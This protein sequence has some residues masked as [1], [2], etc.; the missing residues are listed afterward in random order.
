MSFPA[1]AYSAVNKEFENK[2]KNAAEL[3]EQHRVYCHKKAPE[4]SELEN[5][6]STLGTKSVTEAIKAGKKARAVVE[7]YKKQSL[8]LQKQIKDILKYL[9]LDESYLT[10]QYSCKKCEDRG[11]IGVKMCDCYKKEL[12]RQSFAL[13]NL[14]AS[15]S[16]Q[17]F[18]NFNLKYYSDKKDPDYGNQSAR[19][20]IEKVFKFCKQ[21]AAQFSSESKNLMLKGQ[22][23]LG[24][25]HLS[26][27]IAKEVIE[28]G[29]WVAYET[30]QGIISKL[31]AEHF[32]K[33]E[34]V[35]TEYLYRCDLLIMDDLGAEFKT[36]FT[37]SAL[38][39]LIN[40]RIVSKKTTIISTNYT[41]DE[42]NDIYHER[43]NSRLK[44]DFLPLQFF[45]ED[46]RAKKQLKKVKG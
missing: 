23:G 34:D 12:I 9:E 41:D 29:H 45:G 5:L 19:E 16:E 4:I 26:S 8:D 35:K 38:Y 27:A 43:I 17:T 24:K 44:G 7:E 42:I 37:E 6:K 28:K 46:I 13:S 11:Y 36:S 22:C 20:H 1:E 40:Q 10:L 31:E 2:R 33:S 32:G 18:E 39:N 15:L 21:Y 25:T 14:G 3:L 30:T